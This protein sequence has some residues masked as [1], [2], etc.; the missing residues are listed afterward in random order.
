MNVYLLFVAPASNRSTHTEYNINSEVSS[1]QVIN[2]YRMIYCRAFASTFWWS[3]CC[4]SSLFSSVYPVSL[5][6]ETGVLRENR[7]FF[8]FF[9]SLLIV[10]AFLACCR[11]VSCVQCYPCFWIVYSWLPLWLS[12][13]FIYLHYGHQSIGCIMH[14]TNEK[15]RDSA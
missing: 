12:L 10:F 4:W 5:V 9:F 1:Q 6:E 8:L 7:C 14:S 2:F 3:P 11:P 13:M 15:E